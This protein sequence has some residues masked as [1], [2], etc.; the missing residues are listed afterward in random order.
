MTR[1]FFDY[2]DGCLFDLFGF[3]QGAQVG[4][5][6]FRGVALRPGRPGNFTD[7]DIATRL[8]QDALIPCGGAAAEG[9]IDNTAASRYSDSRLSGI[10]APQPSASSR[11]ANCQFWASTI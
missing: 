9:F 7:I 10:E 1:R 11:K 8:V 6:W 5:V 2:A 4:W 3:L